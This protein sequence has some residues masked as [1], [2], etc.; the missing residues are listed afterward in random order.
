MWAESPSFRQRAWLNLKICCSRAESPYFRQKA[1]FLMR[2]AHNSS[3]EPLFFCTVKPTLFH[4]GR[5]PLCHT[6]SGYTCLFWQGQRA[7]KLLSA[8]LPTAILRQLMTSTTF[9]FFRFAQIQMLL[10]PPLFTLAVSNAAFHGGYPTAQ[11][12]GC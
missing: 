12:N 2:A 5:E 4:V 6:V 9:L 7:L 10:L 3:S 1:L 8:H 11:I